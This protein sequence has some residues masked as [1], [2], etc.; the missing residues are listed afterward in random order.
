MGSQHVIR[1][2]YGQLQY[3]SPFHR[4][5]TTHCPRLT[6]YGT[7]DLIVEPYQI[8]ALECTEMPLDSRHD[9]VMHLI[10]TQRS[11]R[12]MTARPT[13]PLRWLRRPFALG[14]P[15]WVAIVC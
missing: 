12:P 14:S 5:C 9:V 2:D 4:T 8:K 13:Q 3:V 10:I 11:A 6:F 15:S 7:S 1:S